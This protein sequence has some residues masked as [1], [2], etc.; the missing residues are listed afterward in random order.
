MSYIAS[1]LELLFHPNVPDIDQLSKQHQ[2][3]THKLITIT[4][5]GKLV[6]NNSS[7]DLI[8]HRNSVIRYVKNKIDELSVIVKTLDDIRIRRKLLRQEYVARLLGYSLKHC[9]SKLLTYPVCCH[10]LTTKAPLGFQ[11]KSTSSLESL[12]PPISLFPY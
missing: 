9:V 3:V 6:P 4:S 11:R 2:G 8:S 7:P 1:A 12:S 5:Y 10:R